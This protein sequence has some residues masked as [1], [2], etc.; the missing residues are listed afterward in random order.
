MPLHH[1]ILEEI[2]LSPRRT[3]HSAYFCVRY[4]WRARRVAQKG[5]VDYEKHSSSIERQRPAPVSTPKM[6]PNTTTMTPVPPSQSPLMHRFL[7]SGGMSLQERTRRRREAAE[8]AVVS[9]AIDEQIEQEK[10]AAERY[11]I[12]VKILLLGQSESGQWNGPR[13]VCIFGP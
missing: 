4:S 10:V 7:P 13:R 6:P 8:A 11:R 5:G 3:E 1:D 9:N 12:A 2:R